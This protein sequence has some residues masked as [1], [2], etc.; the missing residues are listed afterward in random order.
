V[1]R[2]ALA[3]SRSQPVISAIS[4]VLMAAMVT[5]VMLTTG[6]AVGSQE[7][8]LSSV[9]A[10]TSRSIVV[11]AEPSAGLNAAALDRIDMIDGVSWAVGFGPATDAS[12]V[13]I[14][15]GPKVPV[16]LAYA[17]S[18]ASLG[19]PRTIPLPGRS[20][21]ASRQAADQMGAVQ[22]AVG[23]A[24]TGGREYSL[25]GVLKMPRNLRFLEPLAIVPS[26]PDRAAGLSVMVVVVNSPTMA[27]AVARAVA[28]SLGETDASKVTIESSQ[29]LAQL[30]KDVDRQLSRFGRN[31]VIAILGITSSLIAVMLYSLVLL[32]RKDF[33]R[34]RALG[35]S[36]GF[37]VLMLLAQ[38][39]YAAVA[40]TIAGLGVSAVI[41]A[42]GGD[43]LPTPSFCLA[44]GVLTV[45]TAL[46]ATALP[47]AAAA[48]RDPIRELRVP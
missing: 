38:T 45:S 48:N 3:T 25:V 10:V 34:R 28:S 27:N 14:A 20:L 13:R 26:E 16:R 22:D 5:A 44:L 7:A 41:L 17:S 18:F 46:A 23:V 43:P 30:R 32:R 2:E 9:D 40:S 1:L 11:R 47:A 39:G 8:V 33:G 15:G 35:A 12:N 37:I 42:I 21:Y 36:R 6:K 31:L 29:E 4:F 19:I 24:T